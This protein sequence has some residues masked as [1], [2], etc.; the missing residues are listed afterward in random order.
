MSISRKKHSGAIRPVH[1]RSMRERLF[2]LFA[3]LRVSLVL[4]AV[5]SAGWAAHQGYR[6]LDAP[7][8][9]IVIKGDYSNVTQDELAQWVEPLLQGGMIS[10][11]LERL[12]QGME[13]HA[14]VSTATVSRQ[15][16]DSIVIE[17]EEEIPVARWGKTGFL[18]SSGESLQIAD[19]SS[20]QR[21]PLL[22]GPQGW[23]K[24]VMK[25]Y[26]EIA[27]EL[28][29]A[30]LRVESVTM[31]ERGSWRLTLDSAPT[32]VLGRGDLMTKIERFVVVWERELKKQ[33]D[34]VAQLDL[35]YDNGMAVRWH[36]PEQA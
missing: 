5:I 19:N 21:L 16:P 30:G 10:L 17:V 3:V 23:E 28:L 36:K 25:H 24:P 2:W 29:K 13:T 22:S 12:R 1:K 18:N 11:N 34:R 8:E 7:V 4:A 32:L 20:L 33:A 9:V 27:G 6:Y 26:R 15:W 35:R 31:S 14:W